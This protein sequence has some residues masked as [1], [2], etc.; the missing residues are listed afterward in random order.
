MYKLVLIYLILIVSHSHPIY[1]AGISSKYI[2]III[3]DDFYF[4]TNKLINEFVIRKDIIINSKYVNQ[5]FYN[6]ELKVSDK[7]NIFITKKNNQPLIEKFFT[8]KNNSNSIGYSP[9]CLCFIDRDNIENIDDLIKENKFINLI[10]GGTD[11]SFY[12]TSKNL[13]NPK[14]NKIASIYFKDSLGAIQSLLEKK[15]MGN[16]EIDIGIFPIQMCVNNKKLKS[17]ILDININNE[18]SIFVVNYLNQ[19]IQSFL[20]FLKSK[21]AIDILNSYGIT[22]KEKQFAI[23]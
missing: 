6:N 4:P 13:F 20:N 12:I 1:A 17:I 9:Y 23:H 22:T 21:V 8:I 7:L 2:N 19:D 14:N 18:Y 10:L 11:S 5:S 16:Q 3:D 15:L